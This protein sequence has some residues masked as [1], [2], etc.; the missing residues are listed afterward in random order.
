MSYTLDFN[1]QLSKLPPEQKASAL[2][3]K[4]IVEDTLADLDLAFDVES[5][6]Q[7]FMKTHRLNHR[8]AQSLLD[9]L[10]DNKYKITTFE[11]KCFIAPITGGIFEA[12]D[13]IYTLEKAVMYKESPEDLCTYLSLKDIFKILILKAKGAFSGKK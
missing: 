4:R 5:Q 12:N 11:G 6:L 10:K 8:S 9:V 13:Y 3:T 2:S 7:K 1:R